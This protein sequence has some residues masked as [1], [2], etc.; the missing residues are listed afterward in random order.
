[1]SVP[2]CCLP[3]PLYCYVVCV[4]AGRPGWQRSHG[5]P[6]GGSS[7]WEEAVVDG[8]NIKQVK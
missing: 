3:C 7:R 5:R 2:V 1:M 8:D 6:L 4:G